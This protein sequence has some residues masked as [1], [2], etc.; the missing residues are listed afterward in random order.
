MAGI[1]VYSHSRL[2]TY[3]ECPWMWYNH[4]IL[5]RE[6]DSTVLLQTGKVVHRAVELY[7]KGGKGNL[8]VSLLQALTEEATKGLDLKGIR[9]MTET[10]IQYI[11]DLS[12]LSDPSQWQIETH[13]QL[14]MDP[15][16][17]FSPEIQ[18]YI[19]FLDMATASLI[20]WKSGYKVY[21][22]KQS[23]QLG[24]YA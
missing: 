14:P 6:E 17:P 1:M 19:D 12:A 15:D 16:D 23:H 20:D 21:D 4:Y 22:A 2:T 8:D 10:A 9:R 11:E 3:E 24:L 13:F 5:G 7:Y 18:G